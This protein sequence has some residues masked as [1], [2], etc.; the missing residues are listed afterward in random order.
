YAT[1]TYGT[2]DPVYGKEMDE[3][4][5][6]GVIANPRVM[7]SMPRM[8]HRS[9]LE[10]QKSLGWVLTEIGN[11]DF[12][13]SS[14]DSFPALLPN[15]GVATLEETQEFVADQ[16]KAHDEGTFFSGYN[17]YAMIAQKGK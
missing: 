11:A 4:I 2:D 14:L 10:L 16:R 6:S 13:L 9:G 7:R 1:L 5:I 8:F 15:A 12:F 17:F 3:K